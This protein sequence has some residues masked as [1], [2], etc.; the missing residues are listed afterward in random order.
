MAGRSLL[1]PSLPIWQGLGGAIAPDGLPGPA[2][3]LYFSNLPIWQGLG[4]VIALDRFPASTGPHGTTGADSGSTIGATGATPAGI[5]LANGWCGSP[6]AA[7]AS[8]KAAD[9]PW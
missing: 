4:G 8:T 9:P 1:F 5:R 6:A 7:G 2:D 3:P